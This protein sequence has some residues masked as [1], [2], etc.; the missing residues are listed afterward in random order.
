MS[1]RALNEQEVIQEAMTVLLAHME[2]AKVAKFLAA[3]PVL[4]R[5][6]VKLREQLFACE[7]VDS[8]IG[9][10]EAFEQTD[11][12]R[13]WGCDQKR[14]TSETPAVKTLHELIA[15]K[16][17]RAY[18]STRE[19]LLRI[20]IESI[21]RWLAS[22][23]LSTPDEFLRWRKFLEEAMLAEAAFQRVLHLLRAETEEA[24]RWRDFS[25]FAGVLTAEERRISRITRL[26]P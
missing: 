15:A 1:T 18:A 11:R 23:A 3:R 13:W 4:N 26:S 12:K 21:D 16:L 20:P 2:P 10:I 14:R 5:D 9:K 22:G 17:E 6:Y 7:T 8:L 19:A 25:P 24:Q